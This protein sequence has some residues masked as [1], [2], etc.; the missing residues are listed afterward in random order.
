MASPVIG[1][2]LISGKESG[3]CRVT[4]EKVFS[5]EDVQYLTDLIQAGKGEAIIDDIIRHA[6]E[7][8]VVRKDLVIFALAVCASQP[9]KE[10]RR[11]AFL[12]IDKVC[13]N[14]QDLFHFVNHCDAMHW[15]PKIGWGRGLRNAVSRW[16]NEKSPSDLALNVTKYRMRKGWCHRDL[17]RLAHITPQNEGKYSAPTPDKKAL[18]LCCSLSLSFQAP[19]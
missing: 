18:T 2:F 8:R 6:D 1:R 17:V 16:Y 7:S 19:K 4:A 15:R 13:K 12:A 10:I 9:D 3:L 14:A 5:D 11:L